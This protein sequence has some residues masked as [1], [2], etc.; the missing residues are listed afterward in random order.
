MREAAVAVD[1]KGGGKDDVAQGGGT[2]PAGIPAAL[3][4][5]EALIAGLAT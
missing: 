4:S 5:G 1:G 2:N 3:A